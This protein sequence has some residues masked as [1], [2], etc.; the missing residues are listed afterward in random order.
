MRVTFPGALL[1]LLNVVCDSM[2]VRSAP[3]MGAL[4]KGAGN[5]L[6][7]GNGPVFLL[8]A[9]WAATAG[10]STTIIGGTRTD[11]YNDLLWSPKT[12]ALPNLRVLDVSD[13]GVASFNS[14]VA[15]ADGVIIAFD[16]EQVLSD[17]LLEV[18]MP[19]D[20]SKSRRVVVLSR[21]LNGAG[22][23]PLASASKLAANAQVWAGGKYIEMYKEFEAKVQARAKLCESTDVVVVR[24]GTYKGGGP[25]DL[26]SDASAAQGLSAKFYDVQQKDLVNW[27]LIFDC[28][29]RG[30]RLTPG[31]TAK[32]PG[33]RAVFTATSFEVENGDSGRIACASACVEALQRPELGGKDFGVATEKSRESPTEAEWD[34]LFATV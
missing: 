33:F 34:A 5:V 4:T 24:A 21:N 19:T 18:V 15:E 9:K 2:V 25:G 17:S 11:L 16:Q 26:T 6:V 7:V 22:L 27:Q 10:Y 20:S 8:A 14:A 32:G 31:D 29:V 23:G 1:V 13:E 28:T 30:V 12:P 3:R